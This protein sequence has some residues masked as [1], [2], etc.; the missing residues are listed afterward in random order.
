MAVQNLLTKTITAAV[1]DPALGPVYH[2]IQ[3][4]LSALIKG[5]LI[6]GSGGTTIDAYVQTSLDAGVSW[7]DVCNFHFTTA[8][9]NLIFN[10]SALTPV[11]TQ[12]T[13]LDGTITNNTAKDGVLGSL[14]R[15]K[16]KSTGTY[17][18][19]NVLRVDISFKTALIG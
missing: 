13:P 18:G 15:V 19:D 3:P 2:S 8:A 17:T 10:L 11:T 6:Y 14:W 12:Y 1:T 16:Y 4:V 5:Q 9:A 7:A